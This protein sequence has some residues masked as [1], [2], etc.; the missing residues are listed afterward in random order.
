LEIFTNKYW[1]EL[2]RIGRVMRMAE[3]AE[4]HCNPIGRTTILTGPLRAP[5]G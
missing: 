1:N 5:R 2:R 3:E 4:G